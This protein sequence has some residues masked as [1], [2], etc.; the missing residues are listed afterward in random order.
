MLFR[1]KHCCQLC[2]GKSQDK[3]F[4]VHH[5]ER[6]KTRGNAPGNRITL[7]E[8]C[9]HRI[10]QEQLTHL[11]TRKHESLRDAGQMTGMRLLRTFCYGQARTLALCIEWY[12]VDCTLASMVLPNNEAS[13][14]SDPSCNVVGTEWT[15]L[16][17]RS[18]LSNVK[19]FY[20]L[21]SKNVT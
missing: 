5:I 17:W 15:N 4:N 10:H 1:D 8:T 16:E 12:L 20:R 19:Q 11:F 7:S 18:W 9:H 3:I 14:R 13:L 21:T 2:H 6:R